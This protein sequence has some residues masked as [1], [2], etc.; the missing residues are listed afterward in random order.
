MNW[1]RIDN[2]MTSRCIK[3]IQQVIEE[4][5]KKASDIVQLPS[6]SE[7]LAKEPACKF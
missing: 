3:E 5:R 4:G 6:I 1:G 2:M 7:I